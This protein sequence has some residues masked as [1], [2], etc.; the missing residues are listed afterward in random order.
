[1][2]LGDSYNNNSKNN[3]TP[4]LYSNYKLSS[5]EGVDPSSLSASFFSN[6]L[7]LSISP[8]KQN[9]GD[10]IAYDHDNAIAVYLT[11]TK[12]RLLYNEIKE[13]MK[14]PAGNNNVG[15]NTGKDGLV[16]F[17]DGKELGTTNYCLIIRKIDQDT[18]AVNASYAYEF[19]SNY[20]YTIRNFN[21]DTSQF[22]KFFYDNLEVDQFLTLLQTYYEAMTGANAF[23]TLD[24]FKFNYSKLNT[25]I[26]SVMSHLGIDYKTQKG[27]SYSSGDSYFNKPSGTTSTN[28]QSMRQSTLNEL[29]GELG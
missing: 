18:G 13:F 7:K 1:M 29:D 27:G 16:M 19:K 5:Q 25:K 12:A 10:Q 11:H 8:L 15:V 28:N 17:S 9:N 26:E 20:H 3:S 24:A 2:A 22:D 14:N 23:A 21:Q 6:M 4:T